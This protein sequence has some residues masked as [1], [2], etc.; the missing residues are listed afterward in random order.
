VIIVDRDPGLGQPGG[1]ALDVRQPKREVGAA[2]GQDARRRPFAED[3]PVG[4]E[5]EP[6]TLRGVAVGGQ[7]KELAV[8]A[9]RAIG[10]RPA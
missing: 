7:A 9:R 10:T 1:Q 2:V 8:E 3:E 4:P 5:T 6:W